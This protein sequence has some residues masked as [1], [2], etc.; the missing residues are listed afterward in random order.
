MTPLGLRIRELRKKKGVTLSQM[1]KALDVTPA[2]LSALEH[3]N[4]GRPTTPRL[5]QICAYFEIIWD[6]ADD[7]RGLAEISQPK[8]TINTAG[9]SSKATELVNLL[10]LNI[11]NMAPEKINNILTML[12]S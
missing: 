12:R 6:E 10:S 8:V 9:L 4:R 5:H 11:H 3:G 2:Y 7:L 1:A